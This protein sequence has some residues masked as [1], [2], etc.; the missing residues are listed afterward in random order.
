MHDLTILIPTFN[1]ALFFSDCLDSTIPLVEE[2]A[3]IIVYDSF[4]SDET[5]NIAKEHAVSDRLKILSGE[6]KGCY[7]AWNQLIAAVGT[8]YSIILTSDDVLLPQ[9]VSALFHAFEN[10]G[11]PFVLGDC[12]VINEAGEIIVQSKKNTYSPFEFMQLKDELISV[13]PK[14]EFLR[15]S[16]GLGYYH[17]IT[18]FIFQTEWLK[19]HTFSENSGSEADLEWWLEVLAT[20]EVYCSS[21]VFSHWRRR[22]GQVSRTKTSRGYYDR[23]RDLVQSSASHFFVD[24]RLQLFDEMVREYANYKNYISW[25]MGMKFGEYRWLSPIALLKYGFHDLRATISGKTPALHFSVGLLRK[26]SELR[27]HCQLC[28]SIRS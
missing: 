25:K 16:V 21:A 15:E 12:S 14:S 10:K 1:S 4:S 7:N 28:G 24:T 19:S 23:R 2:G 8:K 17:S 11:V 3:S 26:Y 22:K 13:L 5:L 27:K 20:S 6:P 18:S 9:N